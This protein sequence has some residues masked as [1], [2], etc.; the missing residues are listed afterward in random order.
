MDYSVVITV[1]ASKSAVKLEDIIKMF[2]SISSLNL[3][4][5]HNFTIISAKMLISN[6]VWCIGWKNYLVGKLEDQLQPNP[7]LLTG[8][9]WWL[10]MIG[11]D[12]VSFEALE[13]DG[14]KHWGRNISAISG[15]SH[16]PKV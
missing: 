10:W 7:K 11:K 4:E 13:V 2:Q 1:I 9:I 6:N 5:R 8:K 14:A 16:E 15:S 3:K 12:S